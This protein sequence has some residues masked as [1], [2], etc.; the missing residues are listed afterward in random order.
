MT[1]MRDQIKKAKAV[2]VPVKGFTADEVAEGLPEEFAERG[3]YPG[4]ARFVPI[5]PNRR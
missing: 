3:A 4:W 2:R 1:S 5:E